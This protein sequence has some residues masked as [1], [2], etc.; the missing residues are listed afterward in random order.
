[1]RLRRGDGGGK[2]EGRGVGWMVYLTRD[3]F[4][5]KVPVPRKFVAEYHQHFTLE[6]PYHATDTL[7]E[8]PVLL[9]LR[10]TPSS[11]G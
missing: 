11:T 6:G 7:F 9:L 2:L 1:M 10:K 4:P 5:W 3:I 8:C